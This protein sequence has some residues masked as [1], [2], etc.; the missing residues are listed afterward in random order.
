VSR[1]AWGYWVWVVG[2]GAVVVPELIAVFDA[3]ALPFTTISRTVGH[4]ERH[5]NWVELV[6]VA[7]IVLVVYSTVRVPPAR[8]PGGRVTAVP[9]PHARREHAPSWFW[10]VALLG[11]AAVAAA[12]LAAAEWWDEGPPHYRVSYVLYGTLALLWVVVPSVL[13]FCFAA[14][15]PFPTFFRTIRNAED[16]LTAAGRPTLAWLLSYAILA[17]LVL[18][19]L[20]LTLYPFPHRITELLNP[21]G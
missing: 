18:L 5:H 9:E 1:Q 19:L 16:R 14:D 8:T 21:N 3:G 7:V 17:G 15:A 20:H 10:V 4:L 2:A 13:A 11:L 12:S 6:V